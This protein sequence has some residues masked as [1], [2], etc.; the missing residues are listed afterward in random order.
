MQQTFQALIARLA[1]PQI[2]RANVIS[3]SCPVPVFGDTS[4]ARVATVGLNPSN[5][6]FVG[7]DG[8]ELD[9]VHR[10]FHTLRSLGLNDWAEADMSHV[11]RVA[12]CCRDYFNRNPYDAWF[13]QLDRILT[14]TD[15]SYYSLDAAAC[16]V[17]LA[18]YATFCKWTGLSRVQRATLQ[19]AGTEAL[20][21]L[22]GAS[23]IRLLILNGRSVVEQFEAISGV[24]LQR[25][26]MPAWQLARRRRSSVQGL[27]YTGVVNAVGTIN[28]GRE[29]VVGG[30]NHNIQSSFGVSNA[31][32]DS[33]RDWIG[34]IAETVDW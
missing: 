11:D 29:I 14:R 2:A 5:R 30:F 31:V 15:T 4:R 7:D 19:Q 6:E 34:T 1:E 33:I 8:E 25:R 22:L 17:D 27:A 26:E 16:H 10:R 3:W 13:R 12:E 28:L 21:E 24:R 9:G 18:P 23:P 32:R 20:G